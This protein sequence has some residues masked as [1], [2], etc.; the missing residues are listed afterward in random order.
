M[1]R[2][3]RQVWGIAPIVLVVLI[4]GGASAVVTSCGTAGNGTTVTAPATTQGAPLTAEVVAAEELRKAVL[5]A[6]ENLGPARVH[7]EV[8][9]ENPPSAATEETPD[10][11]PDGSIIPNSFIAP[12]TGPEH[13]TVDLVLDLENHRA[14]E[15]RA[16][17]SGQVLTRTSLIGNRVTSVLDAGS[18]NASVS[19]SV[20]REP[21]TSL[22]LDD[23]LFGQGRVMLEQAE[24]VGAETRADGSAE[25]A[26]RLIPAEGDPAAYGGVW[27]GGDVHLV[28]GP[29]HL[30][31]ELVIVAQI[32]ASAIAGSTLE[33]IPAPTGATEVFTQRTTYRIESVAAVT[34]Q[35]VRIDMP[36]GATVVDRTTELPL[37]HP[38]SALDWSG[39]W[40]GPAFA[41]LGLV[42]AN[43]QLSG[44]D[45]PQPGEMI[46]LIYGA[47][48]SP[49]ALA[50][51][52]SGKGIVVLSEGPRDAGGSNDLRNSMEGDASV[53][54]EQRTVAGRTATVRSRTGEGLEG[55]PL[56]VE[57]Q[58]DFSDV[59][60]DIMA[61]VE[62]MA[63]DAVLAALRPM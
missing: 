19:E 14:L 2:L 25:L 46:D 40:L 54:V 51:L 26:C 43:Q 23:S 57:V 36:A 11:M 62:G 21:A 1:S 39:Y 38:N 32:P 50:F 48:A 28:V 8:S 29:D 44:L 6:L 9:T 5:D 24:A 33:S 42:V 31:R 59:S 52:G 17:D 47:E 34:E 4:A 63:V 37:D 55:G 18:T 41:G 58:V 16:L 27:V 60:L 10:T 53:R 56:G 15:T 45:G 22:P 13:E 35:D 12:T 61:G 7:M 30:P 20:L 3:A 49:F